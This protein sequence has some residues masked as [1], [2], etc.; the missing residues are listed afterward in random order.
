MFQR[1]RSLVS[2]LSRVPVPSAGSRWIIPPSKA[3]TDSPFKLPPSSAINRA[4]LLDPN[5]P[6]GCTSFLSFWR[7]THLQN[8]SKIPFGAI[9]QYWIVRNVLVL[10]LALHIKSVS[11]V[12]LIA[13][14]VILPG[15]SS[16]NEI[17]C[18]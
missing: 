11:Q 13:Q 1:S 8:F 4:L 15:P 6:L 17:R 16:R 14:F 10:Q 9:E 2:V 18:D 12:Y 3:A 7:E 5:I